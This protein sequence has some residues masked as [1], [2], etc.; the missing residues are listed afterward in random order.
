MNIASR[1]VDGK[2]STTKRSTRS[3]L[4]LI[5]LQPPS[6]TLP[7]REWVDLIYLLKLQFQSASILGM[8]KQGVHDCLVLLFRGA[9]DEAEAVNEAYMMGLQDTVVVLASG[10]S[11]TP[12]AS[13]SIRCK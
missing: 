4:L 8:N 3:S 9:V 2:R 5:R 12:S 1:P 11:K 13:T 7:D 10:M 6:C